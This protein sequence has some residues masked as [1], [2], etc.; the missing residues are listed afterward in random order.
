MSDKRAYRLADSTAIEPLV[1]SWAAWPH[2][3]PPMTS[4]LYL[5]NYQLKVLESFLENP[6]A[7]VQACQSR[8]LRSGPFVDLGRERAGEVEEFLNKTKSLMSENLKL[9]E[10]FLDFHKLLVE[11]ATGESLTPFYAQV[12]EPL[13]GY[14]ELLYDYYNHPIVRCLE[15]LL[16]ESPYYHRELQSLLLF[17]QAN[18]H[19]RPFFQSTPRLPRA[20]QINWTIPFDSH[21]VDEFFKL[22]ASPQ[23]LGFIREL[24]GLKPADDPLLLSLLSDRAV[25][26]RESW[27]GQ[28]VRI[29]TLGHASALVEW[30]GCSILIDPFVSVMPSE[31]GI[32]RFTYA[33]LPGKIDYVLVTHLHQ[34]HFCLET[35][36]RLRHR[37]GCLVVPRSYGIFHGDISLKLLARKIGFPNVVEL[38]AL[39]TIEVGP[40]AQVIAVPF[41]GEHADLAQGKTGY[42]IRAGHEQILFG[43]DSDCLDERMYEHLRRL[44]GPIQTVF[45]GM[46]CVGGP[47]TWSCGPLLP[48]KP[49]YSHDQSRR[50][51]GAD[52]ARAQKILRALDADHVYI[53]AMGLEPWVEHLL[54]LAYTEDAKQI[55]EARKMIATSPEKAFVE[56][57]L[58]FGKS[59][60]FLANQPAKPLSTAT[61]TTPA[62]QS[63]E[64]TEDQFSFN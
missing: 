40:G 58:L 27:R 2:I 60:I 1:N 55:K 5:R 62:L 3:V 44:L 35:L 41:L 13:R 53:Y 11:Q 51:H 17:E 34:D 14:V 26:R 24:L 16:Y 57:E 39:E 19:S 8:K 49:K 45:L 29:R 4:S 32:E 23:P 52:S 48:V 37:I 61:R 9:A 25:E 21:L 10:S 56:A 12:P 50:C 6:D 46:E 7:H 22:D 47:L 18:D 54:G 64:Q 38:D 63:A 59:E 43:A 31:G 42:V 36:L 20:D 33:S 30:N 28:E 15:G